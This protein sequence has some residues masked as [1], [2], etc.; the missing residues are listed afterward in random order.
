MPLTSNFTAR[1]IYP[2]TSSGNPAQNRDI[3][4]EAVK[5]FDSIPSW[6]RIASQ[7]G[8]AGTGLGTTGD[9]NPAGEEAWAVW[10]ALSSSQPFDVIM[11]WSWSS[12]YASNQLEIGSSN[13]GVGLAI[14]FHSSS[15]PWNGTTNNNLADVITTPGEP[16]K[17]GSVIF[18]RQNEQNGSNATEGDRQYV[19]AISIDPTTH[20]MICVGDNDWFFIHLSQ[21][22]NDTR[23]FY[24]GPYIPLTTS[25]SEPRNFNYVMISSE[26]GEGLDIGET[27]G[28]TTTNNTINAGVTFIVSSSATARGIPRIGTV[29]LG[30]A[31]SSFSN[32]IYV[33]YSGSGTTPINEL[34]FLI[35]SA[36]ANYPGSALGYLEYIRAINSNLNNYDYLSTASRLI[37]SGNV[38][39]TTYAQLSI[40]YSSSLTGS[41]FEGQV[42]SLGTNF[43]TSSLFVTSSTTVAAQIPV[44]RG[45]N[46]PGT[47]VY[48]QNSPPV[49]ATNVIIIGYV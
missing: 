41:L 49:G 39:L 34:P 21:S 28:S 15:A 48:S 32:E 17:S 45:E 2:V 6:Q 33:S 24:F 14:A 31:S 18:P 7:S 23:W 46:P 3:F 29:R 42:R 30:T 8:S 5:F 43:L 11:K 40:P 20:R 47:Y 1:A 4:G 12:F 25:Y 10:R 16:W 19:A 35:Y 38:A 44:F 13:Y 26:Q 9:P 27:Y 37:L 22:S 36:E